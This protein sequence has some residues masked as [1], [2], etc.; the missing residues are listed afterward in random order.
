MADRVG[1]YDSKALFLK[2]YPIDHLEISCEG[3]E[4]LV[5]LLHADTKADKIYLEPGVSFYWHDSRFLVCG[6]GE[7]NDIADYMTKTEEPVGKDSS[8][9][10]VVTA[11]RGH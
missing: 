11:L 1:A 4:K 2:K 7:S 5:A 8:L 9:S 10:K 3:C 6:C